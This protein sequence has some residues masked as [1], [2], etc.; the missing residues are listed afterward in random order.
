MKGDRRSA[1]GQNP[2][3]SGLPIFPTP[4]SH[5]WWGRGARWEKAVPQGLAQGTGVGTVAFSHAV[6]SPLLPVW[7]AQSQAP[8]LASLL[9]PSRAC[10]SQASFPSRLI[11]ERRRHHGVDLSESGR[12][13]RGNSAPHPSP[14]QGQSWGQRAAGV[15]SFSPQGIAALHSPTG[16]GLAVRL[17]ALC[18]D[19]L[20][21]QT[22]HFPGDSNVL[23][24]AFSFEVF[25]ILFKG[26]LLAKLFIC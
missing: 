9:L 17:M 13:S 2:A 21:M 6:L 11:Q 18:E 23:M 7:P 12:T 26:S 24:L 4:S 1:W 15:P 10:V 8:V 5:H 22:Q 25:G 16:T 3:K 14:S 20:W 19:D